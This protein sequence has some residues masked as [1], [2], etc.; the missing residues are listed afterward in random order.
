MNSASYLKLI[1]RFFDRNHCWSW[2]TTWTPQRLTLCAA[3]SPTRGRP[4]VSSVPRFFWW[5]VESV[6]GWN[7]RLHEVTNQRLSFDMDLLVGREPTVNFKKPS[8]VQ[9]LLWTS[10]CCLG[11]AKLSNLIDFYN[12]HFVCPTLLQMSIEAQLRW[13]AGKNCWNFHILC[14]FSGSP[15]KLILLFQELS[16]FL[17]EQLIGS[18]Q[19][20][21]TPP[22]RC[23]SCVVTVCWRASVSVVR[24][25]PAG[26]STPSLSRGACDWKT[27]DEESRGSLRGQP[28]LFGVLMEFSL[29][30]YM[31]IQKVKRTETTDSVPEVP[32]PWNSC[33][34][35]PMPALF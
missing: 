11:K 14:A 15:S 13:Q 6:F 31:P 9:K 3:S 18:L 10:R 19:L 35:C 20:S 16:F 32:V 1:C 5:F 4:P 24:A 2:C 27:R 8:W 17:P 7:S 33:H 30:T 23:I 25:S 28:F 26:W 21:W 29:C 12:F 34:I 22:W